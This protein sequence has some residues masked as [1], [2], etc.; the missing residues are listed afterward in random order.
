ME[1]VARSVGVTDSAS[2]ADSAD[3]TDAAGVA[4]AADVADAPKVAARANSLSVLI[5]RSRSIA[6]TVSSIS[7]LDP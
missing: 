2:V 4:E 3:V 6:S 7:L 1:A 5:S